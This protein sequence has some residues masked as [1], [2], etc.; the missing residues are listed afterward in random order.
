MSVRVWNT[1]PLGQYNLVCHRMLWSWCHPG[2]PP[3]TCQSLP[4][5]SDLQRPTE[6]CLVSNPYKE[7][8]SKCN[9]QHYKPISMWHVLKCLYY[10]K[11]GTQGFLWIILWRLTLNE[12][13]QTSLSLKHIPIFIVLLLFSALLST[14]HFDSLN[15]KLKFNK[16]AK[17][18]AILNILKQ[19]MHDSDSGCLSLSKY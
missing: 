11:N 16:R 19:L 15:H 6:C 14:A 3:Y 4:A 5:Y 2:F 9:K 17:H 7:N 13:K 1:V 10:V 8:V 12:L 18:L